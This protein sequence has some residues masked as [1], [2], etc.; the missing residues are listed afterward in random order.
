ML[1][2]PR[3]L[4]LHLHRRRGDW[5]RVPPSVGKCGP[6]RGRRCAARTLIPTPSDDRPALHEI[7]RSHYE[8][9]DYITD[10]RAAPYVEH[11]GEAEVG[12]SF[13]VSSHEQ[14]RVQV[15]SLKKYMRETTII[16]IKKNLINKILNNRFY[17]IIWH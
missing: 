9:L 6:E 5:I 10:P 17:A 8:I 16:I 7:R 4:L 3:L 2:D 13:V 11:L 1:R 14:T 15:L 12:F